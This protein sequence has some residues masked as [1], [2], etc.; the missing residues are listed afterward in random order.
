ML[1]QTIQTQDLNSTQKSRVRDRSYYFGQKGHRLAFND[2][3]IQEID[4]FLI[5]DIDEKLI[6][7]LMGMGY[8]MIVSPKSITRIA[9]DIEKSAKIKNVNAILY[10][11]NKLD[12]T[13]V[14]LISKLKTLPVFSGTPIIGI[15][16]IKILDHSKT[17]TVLDDYF[18]Y[19]FETLGNFSRR[20]EFLK[21]IKRKRKD[22]VPYEERSIK[23]M[24]TGKRLFDVFVSSLLI[25]LLT[26]L[27]ILIAIGIKFESSG[28]VFYISKRA[29]SGFKVFDFYKFRSMRA[30]ADKE[31]NQ[32]K[33]LNQY[34]GKSSTFFKVS[35]D[36]RVTRFGKFLRNSSIDELPQ[37]F[38]VL[39][40]DMSMVGNRPL[41]IY[42]A[43]ELTTDEF[44]KRFVGPAGITGL[45][46][47]SKRGQSEM[48]ENERIGLDVDYSY[49]Y[50]FWMDLKIMLMTLPA[51]FQKESV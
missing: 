16:S 29:G 44:S 35:N 5:G 34:Q 39:K 22:Y 37:L 49:N 23:R 9:S 51:M 15:G 38:N 46:Q 33:H 24:P 20:I 12:V 17:I 10:Q 32:L 19:P 27:F 14:N 21:T 50:S 25:L 13:D 31:V 18:K 4:F 30:G 8:S 7:D 1:K 43:E 48:S 3:R 47:V 11:G 36:P 45:W 26:P 28:S 40:G 42:E 6:F 2:P 41:P